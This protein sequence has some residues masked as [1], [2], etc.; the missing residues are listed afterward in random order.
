MKKTI[1]YIGL[2]ISC[3]LNLNAQNLLYLKG[4]I[5][6]E[7]ERNYS[8]LFIIENKVKSIEFNH[9]I[10]FPDNKNNDKYT[11]KTIFDSLGKVFK[12]QRFDK[13]GKLKYVN[14]RLSNLTEVIY[15]DSV[16]HKEFE[17]SVNDINKISIKECNKYK[18]KEIVCDND[19]SVS[20]FNLKKN[21]LKMY[22]S[23]IFDKF[24]NDKFIRLISYKDIIDT[25]DIFFD[26]DYVNKSF[27]S[28]TSNNNQKILVSTG[29]LNENNRII[30]ESF[31][32]IL[33]S[34]IHLNTA[35]DIHPEKV[36]TYFID[37]KG[38]IHQR[39]STSEYTNFSLV[40]T[41]SKITE[42]NVNSSLVKETVKMRYEYYD[43]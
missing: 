10:I 43:K 4:Q 19:S 6:Y 11:V 37:Q 22:Q 14:I 8:P 25:T 23:N 17:L 13:N 5:K 1:I 21:K 42:S 24:G 41:N 18:I 38:L 7:Y 12:R 26:F 20:Y 3:V 39:V 33:F 2:L 9:E 27:I 35:K 29:I 28:Y 32:W 16:K 34:D 36:V 40:T 30:K 15:F 31:Y